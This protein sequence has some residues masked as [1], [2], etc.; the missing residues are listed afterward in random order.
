MTQPIRW[1]ILGAAQFALDHMG[2]A[3]HAARGAT[4]TALATSDLT[5]AAA[6]CALAPG[7]RVHDSYD[8]LLADPDVDAIYIPLPN[9]I[10]VDWSLR[11]LEAGK[12]VLCEKPIAMRE[13]DFDRL[14]AARDETGLL[15]AEAYMIV[16]HPQW[17]RAKEILESRALGRLVH[18]DTVFSFN[19]PD[20]GNIR[21][22][23]DT[24]GG[25][26]RDIGVYTFGS[27]RFVT[28]QEPDTVAARIDWENGIDAT[29]YVD[30]QFPGF[31]FRSVTSMRAHDRQDVVFHGQD[32]IMRL[33]APFNPGNFDV[34]QIT[35]E[36]GATRTTE[37]FVRANH[38][39]NQVEAFGRSLRDGV[40]YPC[41]LEF[42]RGTQAMIDRAYAAATG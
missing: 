41:P 27:I 8:A 39:V 5:K 7:L 16:H 24:G 42:S 29:A 25:G 35:V 32:G 2:P 38:Y 40:A 28:G 22:K 19:N 6:F 20:P 30:A 18:V 21:N 11:A 34:A 26:L 15:A 1:G 36:Q 14:I 12:P 10:H 31:A 23:P 37:R 17:Q 3:I 4:L 9:H 33:S 13:A